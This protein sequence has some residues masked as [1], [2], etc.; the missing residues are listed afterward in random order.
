MND[1]D[2]G[3][4]IELARQLVQSGKLPCAKEPTLWATAGSENRCSLCREKIEAKETGY[5]VEVRADEH[6]K[7]QTLYFHLPCHEAWALACEERTSP[8]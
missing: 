3:D 7:P 8:N 5:E 1:R 6:A 2:S 4:L